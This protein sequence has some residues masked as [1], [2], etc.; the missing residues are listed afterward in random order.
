M[1]P[2]NF[3]EL[4]KC[5]FWKLCLQRHVNICSES[6]VYVPW[7]PW[8]ILS[9]GLEG[10]LA[11]LFRVWNGSADKP[12]LVLWK[13]LVS[14]RNVD[15]MFRWNKECLDPHC[16]SLT[17]EIPSVF[18]TAWNSSGCGCCDCPEGLGSGLAASEGVEWL[19]NEMMWEENISWT[20][21]HLLLETPEVSL[22]Q[23]ALGREEVWE[24]FM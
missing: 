24:C 17:Q 18:Y 15:C 5:E 21:P 12:L 16:L 19:R 8:K 7:L 23:W 4:W 2:V 20:L 3:W 1:V 11:A 13:K 9:W 10:V 14:N 6:Q 22:P